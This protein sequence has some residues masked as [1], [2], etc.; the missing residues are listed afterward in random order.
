MA[1]VL[2]GSKWEGASSG[3]VRVNNEHRACSSRPH[4]AIK[5]MLGIKEFLGIKHGHAERHP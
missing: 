2:H 3:A 4:T 5:E 1:E